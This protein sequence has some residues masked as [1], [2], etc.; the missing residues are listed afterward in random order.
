MG[1]RG[2]TLAKQ[3]ETRA[4]EATAVMETLSDADWNKTTAAERWAVSHE[5]LGGLVKL[6]ADGKPGPSLPMEALHQMNAKHAQEFAGCTRAE[7]IALHKKNAAGAAALLRGI[8]DPAFDR[9]GA[10]F[11]GAPAMSAAQVAGILDRHI[12]EH[13]G[14][15]KATIGR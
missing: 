10:V 3:F 7:T 15:I 4:H 5:T 9:S 8:D 6:L 2:D 12:D 11:A 1:A 14:S 13:L